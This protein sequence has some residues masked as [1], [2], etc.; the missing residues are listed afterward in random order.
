MAI[1]A[2]TGGPWRIAYG[3]EQEIVDWLNSNNIK[4]DRVRSITLGTTKGVLT[5]NDSFS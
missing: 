2:T 3:T 4:P 5:Y 1:T